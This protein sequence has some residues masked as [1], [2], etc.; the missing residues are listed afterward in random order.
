MKRVWIVATISIMLVTACESTD[1]VLNRI[2]HTVPSVEFTTDTL[3]VTAG[4]NIAINALIEDESGIQRIEFTYGDW[5]I[6]NIIDLS[7]E[8]GKFTYQFSI[9]VQVPADAK[10]EW[11]ENKYF[12]DASSI[13]ITQ[14]YHQLVL[15]AWDKNRNLSKAYCYVKVN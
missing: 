4:E 10:K 11:E 2:D 12:N 15:S 8:T 13:K 1:D 5:R 3:E 6:N 14:R 9:D 7:E